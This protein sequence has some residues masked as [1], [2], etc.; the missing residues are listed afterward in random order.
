MV[1]VVVEAALAHRHH[2]G[3]SG[4]QQ[5]LDPLETL[6]GLVGVEPDRGPHVGSGPGHLD[7]RG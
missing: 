7:G 6:A 2:V 1:V 4:G 5:V 3:S